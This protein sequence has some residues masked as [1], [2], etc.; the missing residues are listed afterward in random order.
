[1]KMP[2]FGKAAVAGIGTTDFRALW[3]APRDRNLSAYQLGAD[4]LSL[5]LT[6]AGLERDAVDGVLISRMPSYE[7]FGTLTG[8]QYPKVINSYEGSGRMSGP[9]VQHAAALVEAG[10]AETIACVYSNNGKSAG[11][12]YGGDALGTGVDPMAW[13]LPYGMTSPGA[14][15]SLM[16]RRYVHEYGVPDGALAPIALSNRANAQKNP[17]AVMQKSLDE[18]GYLNSRFIAEPLRL[19]D[20]C[21]INDGAV[22]II[23]TTEERARDLAKPVVRITAGEASGDL[24]PFYTKPDLYETASK[25]VA[26]RL[27]EVSGV[28]PD[29]IDAVQIYDNFTPIVLF[30]LEHFGFAPKG[31]GW[32][33]IQD[34]RIAA[35]GEL[36]INTSGGHTS[37]GYMQGWAL[38]AEAVRQLRGEAGERQVADCQTV[39]YVCVSPIVSSTIFQRA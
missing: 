33:F 9:L 20:Y 35:G 31:E 19:F 30:S 4:A 39:Q 38:Q 15:V 3:D 27:S 12:T 22:A 18:A 25:T 13:E 23:V 21:M 36:P 26:K 14:Y 29:D 1:M 32:K 28:G 8:I 7:Q 37:E 10:V 5:A 17:I 6:D 11:A 34:G 16:Y 2:K 24:G